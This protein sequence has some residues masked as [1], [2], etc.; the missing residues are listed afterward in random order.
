MR[1]TAKSKMRK[2]DLFGILAL[3]WTCTRCSP[4]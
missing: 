1:V 4:G 3:G 2:T